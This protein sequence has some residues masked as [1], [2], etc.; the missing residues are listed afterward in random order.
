MYFTVY[1][2][3]DIMIK[4]APDS[5]EPGIVS[6]YELRNNIFD[7]CLSQDVAQVM[8]MLLRLVSK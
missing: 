4:T 6:D 5:H 1:T 8:P 7:S 3:I 2:K